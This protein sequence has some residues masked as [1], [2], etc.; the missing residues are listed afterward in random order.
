MECIKI[1]ACPND[2]MLYWKY[3]KP[4]MDKDNCDICGESRWITTSLECTENGVSSSAKP[5]KKAAK[6]LRYFPIKP[7]L[8]RLFMC[9]KTSKDMRWHAEDRMKD[10]ALRHPADSEEWKFFDQRYPSFGLESRNVRLGMASDGF[11][12]FGSLSSIHSTWPVVLVPYNLPPWMCMKQPFLIMSLLIPGPSSPGNNIDVY[13]Q[14]MIDELKELWEKGVKTYDASSKQNFKMHAAVLWTINDFPAFDNLSGWSTKGQLACLSCHEKTCSKWLQNGKKFCYMGSR[15]F[16]P[17]NHRYRKN[18][19]SFDNNTEMGVAPSPFSG[20]DVLAQ[21]HGY[22]QITFGKAECDKV[23]QKR[24]RDDNY[25]PHNWKKISVFFDLSYWKYLCV[26]H[27]L[28]VMHIEKNNGE[29]WL[30]T[31]LNLEKKSKDNLKARQDLVL[32]GMRKSLHPIAKEG[33][34]YYLPLAPYTLS[35][36]EKRKLCQFLKGIKVLH[37]FSSNISRRVQVKECKIPGLKSHDWHVLVQQLL[38]V[39]I[40]GILPKEVTLVL[41]EL[42]N[43]YKQLCSKVLWVAR[44]EPP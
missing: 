4:V 26:L 3:N 41:I 43:F 17:L 23:G 44:V 22:D 18:K 33:N 2:C 13:L 39:A 38:P 32:M 31:L 11:N 24:K 5:K 21:L 9:S 27:N 6:V 34:K 19:S 42:S 36:S 16:L 10:G 15:K 7:R 20:S 12:P 25:L 30:W 29:S 40:R 37:N 8:R 1:D 28:D 14:P 35:L